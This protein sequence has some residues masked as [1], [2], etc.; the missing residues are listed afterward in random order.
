M[1]LRERL[2]LGAAT[3]AGR[4]VGVASRAARRGSGASIQ[5]QVMVRI[6]P[7]AFD[8]LLR[9]RTI[10][11]VTG[12]NGKTT[13]THLLAEAVR[14]SLGH[15]AGRLVTNADG[16]NLDYGIASALS[17]APKAD[18]AVLETDERIVPALVRKGRP[19]V[20]VLLN[21]SRDQMD[22]HHE[23][24]G[25]AR[26][27][28]EAIAAVAPDEPVVIG[29]AQDPLV[30]WAAEPAR[31]VIWIDPAGHWT[32]DAALCPSCGTV[33]TRS[34][35][36]WDCPGCPLTQPTAD[37]VVSGEP[38]ALVIIDADGRTWEP[39]LN[40]P[41][42]FNV[43]NAAFALA[44]ARELGVHPGTA[45]TG[46]RRVTSPAGRF[47]QAQFGETRARLVLAKNPAG[48][49]EALPVCATQTI[50]LAIDSVAADGRDV[51]WL[52]DVEY[53]QLAGRTVIA[54]GPRAQDLAV[55]LSYAGV[56]H[57]TIPDLAAALSG[58]PDPV[59][60]I[61][62]YTPFQ[63]LRRMAGLGR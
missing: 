51:S 46:M 33:L 1:P 61:A 57:R 48:W 56:E 19:R 8:K 43:G 45:F 53:E 55:R 50:V 2:R 21:L 18:L 25:V 9:G 52:W 44:A 26:S 15:Q 4:V 22:R 7:D 12:T 58:H 13:T 17:T 30:V 49:A 60:V 11:A 3:T 34:D 6:D 24:K 23:I 28:R 63:R 31:R 62:T 32:A 37:I 38:D 54:T 5:G 36:R 14:A 16:A 39:Q 41:G 40:V 20:L 42:R 10:A 29:N 59:D 47:A 35:S 27:W